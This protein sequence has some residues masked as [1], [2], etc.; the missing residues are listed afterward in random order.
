MTA[1]WSNHGDKW[2]LTKHH[3]FPD[4][5]TLHQ[6]ITETPGMLP[7]AGSPDVVILGKEVQL[8]AGYADLIGVETTGRPVI[9]EVM[10]SSNAE[11]RV[12]RGRAA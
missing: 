10:L 7:P 6:L 3:G 2:R 4:E 8:G 9:V 5:A 11:S 12:P 1:I